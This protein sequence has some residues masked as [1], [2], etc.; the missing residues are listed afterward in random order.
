MLIDTVVRNAIDVN[1]YERLSNNANCGLKCFRCSVSFIGKQTP[2]KPTDLVHKSLPK[3]L[4]DKI[5]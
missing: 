1:K 5:L 3:L 2:E 4:S